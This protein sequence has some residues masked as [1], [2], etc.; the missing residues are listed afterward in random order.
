MG[1]RIARRLVDTGPPIVVF[2]RNRAKAESL[3]SCGAEVAASPG[4]LATRTEVIF[5]CLTD[6]QAV[7]NVYLDAGGVWDCVKPGAVIIEMSTITPEIS[8]KLRTS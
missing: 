6:G 7:R 2:H 5:S 4:E 3:A 8:Q 1:S